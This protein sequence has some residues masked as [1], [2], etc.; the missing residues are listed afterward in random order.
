MVEKTQQDFFRPGRFFSRKALTVCRRGACF[1]LRRRDI[2]FNPA[3]FEPAGKALRTA[4]A[5]VD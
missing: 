5:I 4:G 2:T 1:T 3:R